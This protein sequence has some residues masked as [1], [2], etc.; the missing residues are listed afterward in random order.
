M[1]GSPRPRVLGWVGGGLP[2]AVI[3][4]VDDDLSVVVIRLDTDRPRIDA[5]VGV[6]DAVGGRLR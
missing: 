5:A 2:D 4:D 1:I 6:L 3:G